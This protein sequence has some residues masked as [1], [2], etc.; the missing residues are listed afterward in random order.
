LRRQSGVILLGNSFSILVPLLKPKVRYQCRPG[1]GYQK[2][3]SISDPVPELS[4]NERYISLA[5]ARIDKV[6]AEEVV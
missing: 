2:E 4:G 1:T 5:D 6:L 3:I